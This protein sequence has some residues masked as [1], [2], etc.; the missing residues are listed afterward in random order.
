MNSP[1]L[2]FGPIAALF[3]A[4]ASVLSSAESANLQLVQTVPLPN[5]S[6]RFDHF[7][8]DPPG[9]HLFVAA[10]GNDTVEVIDLEKA[11]RAHS[12]R[13]LHK[14]TG[15]LYL[16]DPGKLYVA[17][18]SDGTF[19]VFDGKTFSPAGRLAALDDADN[20]RFDATAKRIYIGFG[21]GAIGFTDPTAAR[22]LGRV[23]LKAHPESFQLERSSQRI[24]VNVPDAKMVTVID[25]AKSA[26]VAEW[27]MEKFRSNFPMALNDAD[28]RLYVGCRQ[29][30]RLVVFDTSAGKPV[31]DLEI[32]GD[33]DDLF[34]D[35]KRQRIYVSC[36]EG[37]VD[38]IECGEGDRYKRLERIATRA[39]ARTSYFSPDTDRLYL[40]VPQRSG[41]DAEIRVYQPNP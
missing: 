24:F 37:F 7:A 30:A 41:H 11:A 12:I 3:C 8:I 6:G 36:G 14:P 34:Y 22:L 1:L 28:H 23:D 39:G 32:S 2:V 9:K 21:D 15:V 19:R 4:S 38:V 27:P 33:T 17:N 13:D 18:G 10:L 29:P 20:V 5:V 35:G 40:A 26:V 16:A 25:R 31:A